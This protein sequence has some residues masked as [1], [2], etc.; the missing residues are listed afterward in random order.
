MKK[1]IRAVD[2]QGKEYLFEMT[3]AHDPS[4]KCWIS[5]LRDMEDSR[6]ARER[7]AAPTFYGPSPDQAE[8]M[9]MRMIEGQYEEVEEVTIEAED[10]PGEE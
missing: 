10:Y 6:A 1:R 5:T 4:R 9:L 2:E 7:K 8:R 3:V